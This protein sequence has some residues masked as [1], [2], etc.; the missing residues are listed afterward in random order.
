MLVWEMRS[1][2]KLKKLFL[3]PS[4]RHISEIPYPLP[5]LNLLS[6]TFRLM[7]S[8]LININQALSKLY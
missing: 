4:P 2:R 1:T 7:N 6:G 3:D 8:V 5:F